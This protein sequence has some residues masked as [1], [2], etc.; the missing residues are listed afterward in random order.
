MSGDTF[1]HVIRVVL[2]R[3][4][5]TPRPMGLADRDYSRVKSDAHR[6]GNNGPRGRMFGGL[7]GRM[8]SNSPRGGFSATFI[9]VAVCTSVFF[10]DL[11]LPTRY[12]QSSP[13]IA[14]PAQRDPVES[15]SRR[16]VQID[17]FAKAA[18][19]TGDSATVA[20]LLE[21]RSSMQVLLE[22]R[23]QLLS[24]ADASWDA[25]R[26]RGDFIS[27]VESTPDGRFMI[28]ARDPKLPGFVDPIAIAS[29]DAV[30]PIRAWMQF[31]TAQAM[32][33]PQRWGA[34]QGFQ[35]WRF[36][37]YGMLHVNFTH[38]LFNMLG[39]W[40]F[41]P[42]VEQAF[43]RLRFFA[44][45]TLSVIVGALLYFMLNVAGLSVLGATGGEFI[46]PGLLFNNPYL[47]LIGASAGVYGVIL[48]AA[49][50]RPDEEILLLYVLPIPL[51]YFAMA[52]IAIAVLT[53]LRNGQNSGGEAAHLGGAIAGWWIAQRPHLLD[54][55]FPFF[56]RFDGRRAARPAKAIKPSASDAE[57]DRIL[58][59]VGAQGLS[60]LS[61][62]ER[63]S[64]RNASNKHRNR[65][66]R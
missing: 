46:V 20:A 3:T 65:D 54:D 9:V 61:E 39:L 1:V 8:R 66:G 17:E 26:A 63:E 58:D 25:R 51:R 48:A 34:E 50:L 44:L 53:L 23:Q 42:L 30:G 45:F 11:V 38:L 62:R 57:I 2:R 15:I 6:A 14:A 18:R 56:H 12:V 32:W 52:I 33:V 49:W 4:A 28:V 13:W 36:I 10:L 24:E 43:G 21:E 40:V 55:F 60:S 37:G 31:T 19:Q 7:F 64:L 41:G 27:R 29:A 5:Y 47:P 35:F 59:K 22:Q 16:I